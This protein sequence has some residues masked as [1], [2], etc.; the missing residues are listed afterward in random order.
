MIFGYF[1]WDMADEQARADAPGRWYIGLRSSELAG[2]IDLALVQIHGVNFSL[3]E[4]QHL[5]MWN[6]WCSRLDSVQ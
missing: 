5:L 1:F 3:K 4:A 2:V 6:G